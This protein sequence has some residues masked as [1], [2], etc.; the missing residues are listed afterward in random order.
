[1]EIELEHLEQNEEN[2]NDES[3]TTAGDPE[4]YEVE[5]FETTTDDQH[6]ASTDDS[7]PPLLVRRSNRQ[8]FPNRRYTY[9]ANSAITRHFSEI[10]EELCLYIQQVHEVTNSLETTQIDPLIPTPENW[11]QILSYPPHIKT[12]WIKSFVKELKELI[13][14]D[15]VVH[16]TPNI[17][18]PIIPVTAKYRV[19][20][21]ADGLV[22]KLK[23]RIALRGDMMRE[24]M[25]TPDTWCPIA[26]FRALKVFLAFAA[27]YRQRVFQLDYVAAFLQADVLGRKFTTFPDGWKELLSDYPDLHRWLGVP[28]RLKKSLYG[29]RVANLAWDE[30][31]SKWLTSPEIGFVRLPSEGSIYIKRKNRDF[32]AVLNAVDD[33]LYFATDPSLKKWFEDATQERFDVQL[34]GQAVWYLQSRIIQ[35]TDYSIILDQS[36]YAAL[37][38]QRYLNGTSEA[39]ITTQMKTKYS[40]PTPTTAVFTRKDCS[41]T[42]ADVINIQAE[43]GFEYAA[44]VGSLIYLMN[45]YI[46]LN[47]AIRKLAR[48]MQL[49]GKI[50][51]KLLLH[52]LRHLQC[53]RLQGGIKFYSDI[54]K[55]PL[56]S[57]LTS[58]GNN[59]F[60]DYPIVVFSD[61]S[62]QD[63]PDSGRSTGGYLIFMQGAVV[64]ATSTMPQLVPWSTCEAEYCLASLATMAAFYI[65]K[66]Y[67]ELH[68]IDSDRQLTIPLGIDSQSAMDTAI[69][70]KET[71]RTRHFSRR[72]HFIRIAVASSQVILFKIDGTANC[73]NSL[74]KPLPA[75]QLC[76]EA[77]IYEVQV[78]P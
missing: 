33:Q 63:C 77:L 75:E 9:Q 74:T 61:A 4:D 50:H 3:V 10:P 39:A 66:V 64:D 70:Y 34:L 31:Q 71:Q 21:T 27:E 28:L 62:F 1:M 14:K 44:V 32:I 37:V 78:K 25:F 30:T 26:G 2:D 67:N 60:A 8:R 43:F 49:P 6:G 13:K 23:T 52:L 53:Y 20:L 22:D 11:R 45:T 76:T 5:G 15:T 19:K 41:A 72:F 40:T 36:R 55:S 68:G 38:L 59:K 65:R 24:T 47:Y 51:F 48:F 69:S 29:D 42:Y 54:S 46:R 16:E 35:C 7:P 12:L 18:D 73:A 17:D 58:T 56:Y 57:H